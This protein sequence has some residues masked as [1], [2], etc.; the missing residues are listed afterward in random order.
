MP[1]YDYVCDT[2]EIVTEITHGMFETP[3]ILCACGKEMRKSIS[4]G[5]GFQLKGN[6]W[7]SKGTATVGSPKRTKEVGLGVKQ[8]MEDY[9]NDDLK[10][11]A[12]KT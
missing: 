1:A 8:G 3:Q 2:C 7:A 11:I 5:T 12:R 6:G 9:L 10:K 4:G